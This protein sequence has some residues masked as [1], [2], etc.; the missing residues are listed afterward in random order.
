MPEVLKS[1]PERAGMAALVQ[2][3]TDI[4]GN[5]LLEAVAADDMDE[6]AM[7]RNGLLPVID[8]LRANGFNHLLDIGGTDHHPLSPRFEISYHFLSIPLAAP[9]QYVRRIRLR[10]FVDDAD[11]VV[12]TLTHLWPSANWPEREIYDQ[13]GVRFEGHPNLQRILNPLDWRGHPLRKD[14]PLRGLE[15]RFVPGGHIGPV[16]PLEKS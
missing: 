6:I 14:Y 10:V 4:A 13:F 7:R 11:H 5:E 8:A 15:R 1:H 12:P 16:P 3:L 2:Q 9:L